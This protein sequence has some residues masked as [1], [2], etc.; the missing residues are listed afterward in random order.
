MRNR[1]REQSMVVNLAIGFALVLLMTILGRTE[2]NWMNGLIPLFPT[3]ALIGQSA[4]YAARG[5]AAARSVAL[6]G[7]GALIP[8]AAYL[9]T[10][11]YLSEGL[12][13]P[14]AAAIGIGLWAI[15]AGVLIAV[16]SHL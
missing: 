14:R 15:C 2:W 3:F 11:A 6:V 1:A 16:R 9:L 10:V 4:T 13:F 5:D 12:G 7:L 8:Y